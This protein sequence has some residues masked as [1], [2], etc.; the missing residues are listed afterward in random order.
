M[1]IRTSVKYYLVGATGLT[2]GRY[3]SSSARSDPTTLSYSN[4]GTLNETGTSTPSSITTSGSYA[5]KYFKLPEISGY[6]L[7]VYFDYASSSM[8]TLPY[9][10][11]TKLTVTTTSG[12]HYF[13]LS[14]TETSAYCYATMSLTYKKKFFIGS[15]APLKMLVG[16]KNVLKMYL[17]SSLIYSYV[18][19]FSYSTSITNGYASPS[20]G[21]VQANGTITL[22]IYPDSGD[23]Y[24]EY[25]LPSSIAVSGTYTN[26]T[27]SSATG[28]VTITGVQSDITISATCSSTTR[29]YYVSDGVIHGYITNNYA[30][31]GGTLSFQIIPNSGYA[32]PDSIDNYISV[33][34]DSYYYDPS[35]GW[36][37][38]YG[39]KDYG[40]IYVT[41]PSAPIVIGYTLYV[42]GSA[43]ETFE[44]GQYVHI[45]A[46]AGG[47][48]Y[49]YISTNSTETWST[50]INSGTNTH[51][52]C[53]AY[54]NNTQIYY[55]GTSFHYHFTGEDVYITFTN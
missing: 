18:Q 36:V 11:G 55:G 17:E 51:K 16:T 42:D 24:T 32:L 38:V 3:N 54:A 46:T 34:C 45:A 7:E 1:S 2:L 14:N 31:Y 25:V 15:K 39:I 37:Y 41:C 22:T 53:P 19:T 30:A 28:K 48:V 21:S 12:Y 43:V 4:I 8:T 10:S 23:I 9:N 50:I 13:C 5:Y 47:Y 26:K 27:Y 6:Y 35:T 40:S 44:D 29:Y 49:Y 52:M 20:S 33:I